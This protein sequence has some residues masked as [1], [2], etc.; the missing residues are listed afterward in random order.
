MLVYVSPVSSPA[1]SSEDALV[2]LLVNSNHRWAV[3]FD[4]IFTYLTILICKARLI[5]ITSHSYFE[6]MH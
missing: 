1:C 6:D 5:T 3:N 4:L 2:P